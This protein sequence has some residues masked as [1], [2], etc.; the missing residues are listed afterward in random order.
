MSFDKVSGKSDGRKEQ[1][2]IP[3]ACGLALGRL[4]S[5]STTVV[6]AVLAILRG[7]WLVVDHVPSDPDL[8]RVTIA[9]I[10]DLNLRPEKGKFKDDTKREIQAIRDCYR[11]GCP[12]L[13]Q[14]TCLR[15]GYVIT[16]SIWEIE[17]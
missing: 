13:G 16:L 3:E 8:V 2:P 12:R 6:G 15:P 11:P 4:A 5:A 10:P 17:K 9:A 7:R 14:G 1:Q